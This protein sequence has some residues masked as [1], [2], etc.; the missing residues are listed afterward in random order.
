MLH[1]KTG[2][3]AML[4]AKNSWY[5]TQTAEERL[6]VSPHAPS[7]QPFH[8]FLYGVSPADPPAMLAAAAVLLFTSAIAVWIPA[9]RAARVDPAVTRRH[10]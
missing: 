3:H 5:G 10:D 4:K 2:V 9:R 8:S 6:G 1:L 7:I